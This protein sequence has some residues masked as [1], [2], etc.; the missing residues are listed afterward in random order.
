MQQDWRDPTYLQYGTATQRAAYHTLKALRVFDLLQAFDPVLAGTI[1]LA[2]DIPGS[3]LDIVCYAPDV[4]VFA[5]HVQDTFGHYASFV[6]QRTMIHGLPTVIGQ[7]A[8][9]GF[10]LEI[11]GQPVPVSDQHAFRHML[12]EERLLRHGGEEIRQQIR[13]RKLQ[14][15]KTEP[16]FAA[17]F[18]LTGDPYETLL[19]LAA[20]S[21]EQL[22]AALT[23]PPHV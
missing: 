14:G 11:F 6:L 17:V 18:G 7:F 9:H 23:R 8:Y 5:Q 19:Q 3:D 4:E 12:V 2:I 20:L 13:Q 15:N 1:P 22:I 10:A 21:E 16:A